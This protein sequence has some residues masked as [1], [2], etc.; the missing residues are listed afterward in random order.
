VSLATCPIAIPGAID[1]LGKI[2]L[3][4][5]LPLLVSE[6]SRI[7]RLTLEEDD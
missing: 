7:S 5:T 1:C 6:Q 4:R 2:E 3:R